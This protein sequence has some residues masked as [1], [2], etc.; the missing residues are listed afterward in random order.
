MNGVIGAFLWIAVG[1][2]L[3]FHAAEDYYAQCGVPLSPERFAIGTVLLPPGVVAVIVM[4]AVG[5]PLTSTKDR[6]ECGPQ[7]NDGGKD[8]NG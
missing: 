2:G 8:G 5:F 4:N 1:C 6:F 7:V 3:M